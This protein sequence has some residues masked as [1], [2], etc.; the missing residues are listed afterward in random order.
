MRQGDLL[1]A[2]AGAPIRAPAARLRTA[3]F[4]CGGG[5]TR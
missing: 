1:N 2:F 5:K 3:G 4:L